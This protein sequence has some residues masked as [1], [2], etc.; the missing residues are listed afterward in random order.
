MLSFLLLCYKL[1][2]I[3]KFFLK[4][5]LKILCMPLI[6]GLHFCEL[7]GS[8][9]V[10]RLLT[11]KYNYYLSLVRGEESTYWKFST[12]CRFEDS[13]LRICT[14]NDFF[15]CYIEDLNS[16]ALTY[17]PILLPTDLQFEIQVKS[18]HRYIWITVV[19]VPIAAFGREKSI[20]VYVSR[21]QQQQ[22]QNLV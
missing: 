18:S 6:Q 13:S 7:G 19:T 14:A 8:K 4:N 16:C 12:C 21:M 3:S 20:S 2:A 22:Q 1:R 15:L 11:Y 10:N 9:L 5:L 17:I